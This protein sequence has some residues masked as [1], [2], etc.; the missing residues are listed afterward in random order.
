MASATHDSWSTW[1]LDRRFG[2]DRAQ[3]D[4]MMRFLAPVRERLLDNAQLREGDVVLDVGCG[5][6]LI[7]FGALD[8]VGDT[9]RVIF[10]DV[11]EELLERARTLAE[12]AGVAERCEFVHAAA[13]DLRML[14]DSS[15]DAVT[16]RS[17]LIY[18]PDK[19]RAFDEFHRALRPGGRVSAYEP[20]NSYAYPEPGN[21]FLGYDVTPVRRLADRVKRVYEA[22]DVP[23]RNAMQDFDERDLV[24]FAE[25]AGFPEVRVELELQVKPLA[26]RDDWDATENR[27]GNPFVPT[28]R[29]AIEQALS[30]QEAE[31][32]RAYLRP[33]AAAGAGK[34][35]FAVAYLTAVK[36]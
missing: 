20:I 29:E 6:G 28:P 19:Q 18:V 16:T 35:R 22:I 4:E 21:L 9:G 27:S 36:P 23:E 30:P 17:V 7:A 32:F 12:Q 14:T 31:R 2:G 8:R 1:L 5:D 15:V 26:G 3:Y 13:P 24:R 34:Y 10:L 33:L 11:S 25:T